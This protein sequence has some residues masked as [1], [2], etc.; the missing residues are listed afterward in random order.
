MA[1][2][3]GSEILFSGNVTEVARVQELFSLND[4]GTYD[5]VGVGICE[6][7]DLEISQAVG[8]VDVTAIK[9]GAVKGLSELQ[10]VT[11]PE[12]VTT[13]ERSAL[14]DLANLKVIKFNAVQLETLGVSGIPIF[15]RSGTGSG[16]ID[17]KIG[18]GVTSLPAYFIAGNDLYID[19]MP[20]IKNLTF[21]SGSACEE[22]G[23]NA[24]R[25]LPLVSVQIPK[26]IKKI[27]NNAFWHCEELNAVHISDI[28]AWLDITFGTKEA[29]PLSYAKNLYL[30]GALVTSL[31]IP[32]GKEKLNNYCFNGSTSLASVTIP[33]SVQKVG[34]NAFQNCTS[35]KNV[36]FGTGLFHLFNSAFY[37]CTSLASVTIP[38]NVK[39]I[40]NYA[41]RSCERLESVTIR[42]TS[43]TMGATVFG[44]CYA[45]KDIFVPWAEGEV[46][47]APWGAT[48][49]TIHYGSEV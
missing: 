37:G 4:G 38:E 43:P 26:S 32:E 39:E 16:G 2:I 1:Y 29:N 7:K 13:I 6:V 17:L 11:I 41:F 49:A 5:F 36:T 25:Y 20:N 22:I 24:F 28:S 15:S 19:D 34:Y 14:S 40:Q 18:A 27:G 31:E 33:D 42:A 47:G 35:L 12:G 3:N 46:D 8:G 45:L 23:Q 21:D 30:N 48:N 10:S 9:A 44:S